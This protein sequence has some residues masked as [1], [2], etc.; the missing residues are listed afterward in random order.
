MQTKILVVIESPNK[1][2]KLE[3]YLGSGYII[4]ATFGHILELAS[5]G[6]YKLGINIEKDFSPIYEIIKEKQDKINAILDASKNVDQVYIASDFDREG[7][8]I[9]FSVASLL[10]NSKPIKRAIFK[11][12]TKR[13]IDE[14]LSNLRD[15]DPNIND[16][17]KARRVLDRII[18]Y[19]TSVFLIKTFDQNNISAGRVQSSLI[20]LVIDRELE[21]SSFKP[22]EYWTV[23]GNFSKK[24]QN[25]SFSA[26]YQLKVTN[27]ETA[28]KLKSELEADT[29]EII[30]VVA[31]EKIK[32]PLPPLI[33]STLLQLA[34]VKFKFPVTKTT[35]IAQ[36]LYETGL[37]TY[38]RTDSVRASDE[39]LREARQWIKDQNHEV[40]E[41]PIVYQNKD[42]AQDAHECIRPTDVGKK[43][44]SLIITDDE[45]KIYG[46][47]WERFIASQMKPALFDSTT[48][49]IKSSSNHIL[50]ATGTVLKYKGWLSVSS[51]LDK[52]ED[53]V[54]L[55]ILNKGDELVLVKPRITIEQKLTQGPNRYKEHSLIKEMEQ[56][57]IGRPSVYSSAISKMTDRNYVEKI[58]D[59][60]HA[61]ELG[62]K[63]VNVLIS[64]FE[65]M[66]YQYTANMEVKLDL[67][68]KGE[69]SYLDMVSEFFISFRDQ[70]DKATRANEKDY[71]INCTL[72]SSPMCL[73]FG[74]FGYFMICSNKENCKNTQSCDIIDNNPVLI[75]SH[76]DEIDNIQCP[77]CN[78]GMKIRKGKFGEFYSCITY[79]KCNG[80]R[81]IPF[82][83]K[84]SKCKIGELYI[85][86]FNGENKLA[87]MRYPDCHNIEN[88]LET[89]LNNNKKKDPI[90]KLL[91]MSRKVI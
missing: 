27:K 42:S 51:D 63:V 24:D 85:T 13:G 49:T 69:L 38:I 44:S 5:T 62:K 18:G 73:R 50:K 36:T 72:C 54:K 66:N 64:H 19:L 10:G 80:N 89:K 47:I 78:S 91:N 58:K 55:P 46:L 11:E 7:E 83:Q 8:N 40:P 60:Y 68:E 76:K 6:K 88:L 74:K 53:T 12:I 30:E 25:D 43:A 87:C 9:A 23:I 3:K 81:K 1:I 48:I 45:K 35:K 2:K 57:G 41:K 34:A 39:S 67:I 37:I 84:C 22:E 31:A 26:K 77:I 4:R 56:K 70:L 86:N 79:P 59:S 21:I 14:G 90:N 16:S 17:Q 71:G 82:G 65:F 52:Q 20:R 61:T 15:L 32:S 28:E 75:N 33:T 29:F